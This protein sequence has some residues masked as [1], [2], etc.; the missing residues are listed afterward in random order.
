MKKIVLGLSI[1]A[2]FFLSISYG[3]IK[4][5]LQPM[6]YMSLKKVC[7]RWGEQPLDTAKFK[8]S[9]KNRS[10]RAKMTCSLLKNRKK[11]IGLDSRE[12]KK[13][14]GNYSGYFFSESFPTYL[15]NS[16]KKGDRNVWQILFFVDGKRKVSKIV[17]HKNCCY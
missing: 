8:A 1:I 9:G 17:V 6:E 12:I 13:I 3:S 14:F 15:I 4:T 11:Y 7:Q 16:A 10:I 5:H 2:S